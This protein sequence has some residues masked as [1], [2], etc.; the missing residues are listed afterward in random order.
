MRQLGSPHHCV[1]LIVLVCAELS[2]GAFLHLRLVVGWSAFDHLPEYRRE[3][4]LLLDWVRTHHWLVH[5]T[6]FAK[7][8]LGPFTCVLADHVAFLVC[9]HS[10]AFR[11]LCYSHPA[12]RLFFAILQPC[13]SPPCISSYCLRTCLLLRH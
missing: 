5:N 2:A 13:C 11:R 12:V 3:C 8:H 9:V 1:S 7:G 4:T 10:C 6:D